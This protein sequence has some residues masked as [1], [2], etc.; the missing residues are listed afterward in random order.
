MQH[1]MP[2]ATQT[3]PPRTGLPLSVGSRID[4]GKVSKSYGTAGFAKEVVH[5]CSFTVEQLLLSSP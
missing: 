3:P 4:V 5:N 2:A 1:V